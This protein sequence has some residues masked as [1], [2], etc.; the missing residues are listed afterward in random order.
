[1]D[2]ASLPQEKGARLGAPAGSWGVGDS[3]ALDRRLK[4]LNW[5]VLHF[6]IHESESSL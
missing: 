6:L 5:T 1:M 3:S 4:C 2:Q